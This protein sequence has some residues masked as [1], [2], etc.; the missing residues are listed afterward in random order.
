M[1]LK[2]LILKKKTS[3]ITKEERDNLSKDNKYSY[4]CEG[5]TKCNS[6][7]EECLLKYYH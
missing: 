2:G 7:I 3:L 4:I 5:C 1:K 6:S